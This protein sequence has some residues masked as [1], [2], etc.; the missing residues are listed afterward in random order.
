MGMS[1]FSSPRVH[2]VA[3]HADD[4]GRAAAF[5]RDVLGFR[6]IAMFDPPG[7]LFFDL[8]NIRL[9]L[10]AGASTVVLYLDVADI[11]QAHADL[12]AKG[13]E[14]VDEPHMIFFDKAGQFGEP[15]TEEWMVFFRDSEANLVAL[16]ERRTVSPR[17]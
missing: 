5:Y 6:E 3:Q 12:L 14:F 17:T 16:V 15:N 11:Q 2:Q 9:L 8:G 7:L 13:V 1:G 10:E 4:L